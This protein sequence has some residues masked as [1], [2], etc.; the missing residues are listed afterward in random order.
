[1]DGRFILMLFSSVH[2]DTD[3][4]GKSSMCSTPFLRSFPALS[5]KQF[6]VDFTVF[7]TSKI[8][9]KVSKEHSVVAVYVR[10][11]RY[12]LFWHRFLVYIVTKQPLKRG[13]PTFPLGLPM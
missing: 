10:G 11:N 6:S 1:M 4:F 2:S 3:I 5:L 7:E 13:K 9:L 8:F 12:V